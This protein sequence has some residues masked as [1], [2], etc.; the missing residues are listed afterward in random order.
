MNS[1]DP[2]V[3]A[4]AQRLGLHPPAIFAQSKLGVDR[5]T[6]RTTFML[7]RALARVT[8]GYDVLI[9]A[10]SHQYALQLQNL[11][12]TWAG[13]LNLPSSVN[14]I[15]ATSWDHYMKHDRM[16][17]TQFEVFIDHFADQPMLELS[18]HKI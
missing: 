8:E 17:D 15:A 6:G 16:Y 5:G 10:H 4:V 3:D 14:T 1:D 9:V 13:C 12:M 2:L 11:A 18:L 7:L